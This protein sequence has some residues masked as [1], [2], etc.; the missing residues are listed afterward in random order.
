MSTPRAHDFLHIHKSYSNICL[1][2]VMAIVWTT[3]HFCYH[4]KHF[5]HPGIYIYITKLS[6]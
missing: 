4:V 5:E 3:G 1:F 6:R 2:T